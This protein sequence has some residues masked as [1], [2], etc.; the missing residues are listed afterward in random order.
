MFER[1]YTLE[2]VFRCCQFEC[3]YRHFLQ[4]S[5]FS[6]SQI[7]WLYTHYNAF[8]AAFYADRKNFSSINSSLATRHITPQ[9]LLPT[10]IATIVQELAA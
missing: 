1:L 6:L 7:D 10:Q 8:R 3:A 5:Q 2:D 9:F 4:S